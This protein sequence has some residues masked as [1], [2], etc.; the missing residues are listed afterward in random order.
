MV[1]AVVCAGLY[2]NIVQVQQGRGNDIIL[3][4][5]GGEARDCVLHKSSALYQRAETVP[6]RALVTYHQVFQCLLSPSLPLFV[7]LPLSRSLS[8]LLAVSLALSLE[9]QP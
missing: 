2:P 4:G 8:L 7:P 6:P 5:Q 1:C 3:R 9:T